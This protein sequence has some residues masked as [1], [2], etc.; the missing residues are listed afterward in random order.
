MKPV[1]TS[2]ILP[3]YS[4][5]LAVTVFVTHG[6]PSVTVKI[7]AQKSLSANGPRGVELGINLSS[8]LR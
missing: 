1:E 8:Q 3:T 4:E 2:S 7:R 6:H 5:Y